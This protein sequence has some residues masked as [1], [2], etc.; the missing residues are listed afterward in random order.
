VNITVDVLNIV[1]SLLYAVLLFLY[2]R[3]F[4][5][6]AS[7][8]DKIKTPV[9]AVTVVIH[10]IYLLL[11][12][13]LFNHP[14]ITTPFEIMS[15]IAFCIAM[16]YLYIEVVSKV[17]GTGLFILIPAFFF[18]IIST[19]YIQDLGQVPEILRNN[20][21]G[22]HVTSA[23][24]GYTAIA[25]GAMYGLLYL[26]LYHDIKS[27]HFSVIYKRLPNLE[28]LESMSF[29]STLFGFIFISVAI[30]V[31]LIWLPIAF[32][33]I[34]YSD[35]KLIGTMFIWALYA[36]G[37]LSKKIAGW[38]GRKVVV[39]YVS[40]FIVALFSITFINFFFSSFHQ[41]Y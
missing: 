36:V 34:F 15:V 2:G 8:A 27:N 9:L 7:R 39:L 3:S 6:T 32:G 13:I 5:K 38:H 17:H 18:Q 4:F 37:L 24:L 21:L 30:A 22:F 40:G 31:G 16:A 19:T 28:I 29:R 35:P 12:T 26:M 23:L 1:L 20:L 25:I 10:L 41:F 14:P 33:E 11:R